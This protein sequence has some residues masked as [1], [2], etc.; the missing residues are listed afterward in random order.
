MDFD[1][2][3]D[4]LEVLELIEVGIPRQIYLRADHFHDLPDLQFFQRFRLTKETVLY[5]LAQIE[6]HLELPNDRNAAV[7]PINQLLTTLRL[8]S[9]GGHLSSVA[10]YMGMHLSTVSRIVKKVSEAIA[11]LYPQII[12]MPRTRMELRRTQNKFF[13]ISRCPRVIGAIDGTHIKIESPGGEHAEVFRNRKDYFSINVQAMCNAEMKFINVVARWPGSTHDATIFNN[14]NIRRDFEQRIYPNC[15]ILG[16]S[17]YPVRRYFLTPMLNPQTQGEQLYNEAHIRTRNVIER[18]FGVWKRRFP[19]LAYGCRLK[20]DTVLAVIIACA[21]LHNI[22]RE[23]GEEDPPL[24]AEINQHELQQ[25][26]EAGN[27]P[28]VPAAINGRE[29]RGAGH[30]FRRSYITNFFNR[31]H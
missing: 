12:K 8:F 27:I 22:A 3:E 6:H 23:R 30:E 16:H 31:Q 24:P 29:R 10:D 2:F 4:D 26:I 7:A 13:E 15:I 18:T 17:G 25:L 21:V 14:S 20:Q 28:E 5:L 11:R 9:T 1:A 19:I